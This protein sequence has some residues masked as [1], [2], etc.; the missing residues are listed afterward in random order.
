MTKFRAELEDPMSK[1]F[2]KLILTK[3]G[4]TAAEYG[5][6]A[7]LVAIALLGTLSTFGQKLHQTVSSVQLQLSPQAD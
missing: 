1:E 2:R 4:T 5:L 6:V 7:A 3:Q